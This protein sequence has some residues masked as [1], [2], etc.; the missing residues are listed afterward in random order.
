MCS[1]EYMKR[2]LRGLEKGADITL[3]PVFLCSEPSVERLLSL[4][5]LSRHLI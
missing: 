1:K 5:F 2:D 4:T 3:W